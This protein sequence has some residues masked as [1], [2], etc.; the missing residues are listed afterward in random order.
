MVS[1]RDVLGV[2]GLGLRL[3][4]GESSLEL[5]IRWAHVSELADPTPWLEGGEL[6]LTTGLN[7]EWSY[8]YAL[9]YCRRL[10]DTG[11]SAL[12]ISTG[13]DVA[14]PSMPPE[15]V[16][17]ARESGLALVDVPNLTPLQAV[18][19]AVAEAIN[20]ESNQPLRSTVEFQRQLTEA[21]TS[22][23]G[24]ERVLEML[25]ENVGLKCEI[26]D[27]RLQ[28][29]MPRGEPLTLLSAELRRQVRRRMLGETKGS[30]TLHDAASILIVLPLGTGGRIRGILV[31]QRS[32]ALSIRE[33]SALKMSVPMLGLLLDLN[34]AADAPRRRARQSLAE[35]LLAGTEPAERL[36]QVQKWAGVTASHVQ[37][38]RAKM[39]SNDQ[40]RS[41]IAGIAELA[42]DVLVR[43]EDDRLTAILCDPQEE[44]LEALVVLTE[45]LEV[46]EVG[47][48]KVVEPAEAVLSFHEAT[49]AR[50]IAQLRNVSIVALPDYRT[51]AALT[52]LG[53]PVEQRAFADSVL[54]PIDEHDRENPRQPLLP[55]LQ[56]YFDAIGSLEI[57]AGEL[58]IHRHTMRA[59][60]ARISMVSGFNLTRAS[61]YLELW[62]AVEFR[63]VNP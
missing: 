52:L 6:L 49:R 32:E 7:A 51:Q 10:V 19:R 23:N 4:T 54:L 17:A 27:T 38:L 13:P 60:I 58:G 28:P 1:L 22:K 39:R 15:L 48:G 29:L 36:L 16:R 41:F 31:V 43:N 24:I 3:L 42:G 35:A 44:M 21:A 14:H 40:R 2:P 33:R 5:D 30:M 62:L 57:A 11:V 34:Y 56:A 63:R 26:Y 25:T 8:E 20:A 46:S 50:D 59:R 47:L 53:D 45:E 55:A 18:V 37:V 9:E 61:E 12:G